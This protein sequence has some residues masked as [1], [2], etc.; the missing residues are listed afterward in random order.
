V[1]ADVDSASAPRPIVIDMDRDAWEDGG[2]LSFEDSELLARDTQAASDLGEHRRVDGL[3]CARAMLAERH[4][5][6]QAS[7]SLWRMA[8]DR[9]PTMLIAF[10]GLKRALARQSAWAELLLVLERR[11]A[12]LLSHEHADAR[13]ALWLEHGRIAED[14]LGRDEDAARS[15]HAGLIDAPD[16]LGLLTSLLLFGFRRA[17]DS[18]IV[19]ALSGYLRCSLPTPLR[20]SIAAFLAR[21]QR[22]ADAVGTGH[23]STGADPSEAALDLA[24][25]GRAFGTLRTALRAVGPQDAGPLVAELFA[26]VH[27]T[28]D[29]ALR[30]KMLDE[31]VFHLPEGDGTTAPGAEETARMAASLLR[32]RARLLRDH[33]N[34]PAAAGRA[35]RAALLRVPGHPAVIAELCDVIEVMAGENTAEAVNGLRDLLAVVAPGDRPFQTDAEGELAVRILTALGREGRSAEALAALQRHP[36]L[37]RDRADVFAL[38]ILLRAQAGDTVGLA[39][40]FEREGEALARGGEDGTQPELRAAAH[41]LVVAGTL[42]ERDGV[43]GGTNAG[44]TESEAM[45]LFRRALEIAPDC[46]PARDAVERRLWATQR[47]RDLA[48]L[49]RGKVEH[50]A[51][52]WASADQTQ[53]GGRDDAEEM[54]RVLEDLIA[55]YRDGLD[56]PGTAR[57]FQD[58]LIRA[59]AEAGGGAGVRAW[60]R[61][62]DLELAAAVR[63]DPS[64][65]QTRVR[66]LR[67][68]SERAGVSE[69]ESALLV[70]A[71]RVA[72]AGDDDVTAEELLR[73]ALV[74]DPTGT[75]A[76]GLERLV[77]GPDGAGSSAARAAIVRTE[78]SRLLAGHDPAPNKTERLCALRFRLAW[79]ALAA[80]DAAGA[81]EA[82]AP[83]RT[84]GNT[85]AWAW[86][87]ESARR[88]GDPRLRLA[89]LQGIPPSDVDS[90]LVLPVDLGEAHVLAGD[91]PAAGLAFREALGKDPSTDAALGLFRVGSVTGNANMILEAGRILV[92]R[93]DDA[94][95]LPL[96]RDVALLALLHGEDGGPPRV[97]G[98]GAGRD[99]DDPMDAV[100]RWTA[101]I[102]GT[103]GV[104]D[105]EA[106]AAAAG[107]LAVA[108]TLPDSGSADLVNDRNGLLARAAT[109]ARLGGAAL[110]G[111]V[112]DQVAALS[113]GAAPIGAGLADLPV[114]GRP[115]RIAAR[116]ARAERNGGLLAYALDLERAEDAEARGDGAAALDGFAAALGRDS[117]GIEALEGIKRVALATGDRQGA[118]RVG[119]RLGVVLRAP[120]R[121]ATEFGVA[122][123]IW[124]DLG[125]LKEAGIAYWQAL[126]RDPGSPWL[127][128]RLH[129]LLGAERDWAGLD[130]LYGHRMAIL[131][132]PETKLDLLLERARHRLEHLGDRKAAIEDFKRILQIDPYHQPSL[133]HLATLAMQME[134]FTQA[135]RFLDRLLAH[136]VD[137]SEV[138]SLC[139]ELAE[140]HEAAREPVRAIEVLRRAASVRPRDVAPWLRLIDLLLRTGDWAGALAALRS[141]DAVLADPIAKAGIWVRIGRLLRDHGRDVSA[142]FAAFVTASNLDP[143][144]EGLRELM[145]LGGQ[146]DGTGARQQ[147]LGRAIASLRHMLA[148]DPLDVPRLRRLKEAY[149]WLAQER[150]AVAFHSLVPANVDPLLSEDDAAAGAA[151]TGQLLALAGEET[152]VLATPRYQVRGAL[153]GDFWSRLRFPGAGGFGADIWATLVAAVTEL[154][155][156][157]KPRA[158]N[159][160]RMTSRT[161]PRLAWV[162]TAAIAVGLPTL[163]IWMRRDGSADTADDS[164]TAIE[165]NTPALL[166][167]RGVLAGNAAARF[168]V[169]WALALLHDDA[170]V[171][172]RMTAAEV[173]AVFGAAAVLVGA[174]SAL[175]ADFVD[176]AQ[177]RARALGKA[178]SRKDR[179]TLEMEASRVGF[180]AVDAAA[181]R[182]ALLATADRFGLL[183]AGDIAVA[184]RVA[185]ESDPAPEGPLTLASIADRGR[186]MALIRFALSDDY[187]ALRRESA[188]GAE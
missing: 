59:E 91:L 16:H 185:G 182:E 44:D 60:T 115:E 100:L 78:I 169:G 57:G 148:A 165:G 62:H 130:R 162:E 94:T 49:L 164:V 129:Q 10:W 14:R 39:T 72:A 155:P 109:R 96:S 67:E 40:A 18:M 28:A 9:D 83:L 29:P 64:D 4:G 12:A 153:S 22:G 128:E 121:A 171:I 50:L 135:V 178:M 79:H 6:H 41:A 134:Y 43:W 133:R 112:H 31:L 63:G 77:R 167:G 17:E 2:S 131:V 161:E 186:V 33:L 36:E 152:E 32:E 99:E 65:A 101:G 102:C 149:E 75:A 125:L 124:E 48:D 151:I 142:A 87:W 160:Q 85:M 97:A 74:A 90:C 38:E 108:R 136:E 141:W 145:A 80:H 174:S 105:S 180:E 104:R 35:L 146:G 159:R 143:L 53:R 118:A 84:D 70:E 93:A 181:L 175:P 11:I 150:G 76:S 56:D 71:A 54:L 126:A 113:A 88:S 117:E 111:A 34:D 23:R 51:R 172:E 157:I 103:A 176:G 52:T 116:I 179:K 122:G 26:L 1:D 187:L 120:V 144:G 30:A 13:A 92:T 5:D 7:I 183:M 168:R 106:L 19:P 132:A 73:K 147:A 154:F 86:S 82:L 137:E 69:L 173:G 140:A 24:V 47:W 42:R 3:L 177:D 114:A 66:V 98:V 58:A 8:F 170:V 81:L 188:A 25:A 27:A 123:Q 95:A 68:L 138:A 15:Y 119:M 184:A 127:Y 107:L 139:L 89:M 156:P 46:A 110:A 163:E 158:G 37:S 61:R 45:R 166:L 20:A 55:I 21:N